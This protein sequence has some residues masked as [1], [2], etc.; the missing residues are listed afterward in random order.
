MASRRPRLVTHSRKIDSRTKVSIQNAWASWG[1]AML[2]PY[3]VLCGGEEF[4][5]DPAGLA[6]VEEFVGID[7]GSEGLEIG[8]H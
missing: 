2:R 7:G 1:A 3:R 5:F 6:V 4:D 8:Q